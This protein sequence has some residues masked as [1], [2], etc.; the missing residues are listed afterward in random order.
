MTEPG[1]GSAATGRRPAVGVSPRPARSTAWRASSRPAPSP[2][3]CSASS[4]RRSRRSSASRP[5][6]SGASTT[7]T[8]SPWAP[9]ATPGRAPE[10]GCRSTAAGP[11]P[12]STT[13]AGP[14]RV[15]LDELSDEERGDV[16]SVRGRL[17]CGVAAPVRTAG[18]L[19]G[20]VLAASPGRRP[21]ARC[22]GP[23]GGFADLVALAVANAED[24]RA[25]ERRIEEQTALR[26]VATAIAAGTPPSQ[27]L[28]ADLRG[29]RP[30]HGL[31]ARVGACACATR[32]R[33]EVVA[34][35]AAPGMP[36][37]D[38]GHVI[39]L[40]ATARPPRSASRGPPG[41]CRA[42]SG[43]DFFAPT[44][45]ASPRRSWSTAAPGEASP[46]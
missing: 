22:G 38:D 2:R 34:S 20:A 46:S 41:C 32:P 33:G 1:G 16:H 27:M 21:A 12:A 29:G 44:A 6:S 7:A 23:P 17:R 42:P 9:G 31:P 45:R 5:A 10:P 13:P 36:A 28:A 35:W 26:R 8:P 24:R 37:P 4:P 40:G 18:R 30:A 14:A 43:D 15:H 19:W 11:W 39:R 3:R 25:I